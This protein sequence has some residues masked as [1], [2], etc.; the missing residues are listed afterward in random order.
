MVTW[1]LSLAMLILSVSFSSAPTHYANFASYKFGFEVTPASSF[2]GVC[3]LTSSTTKPHGQATAG[4]CGFGVRK[5]SQPTYSGPH[6]TFNNDR[7]DGDPQSE[8]AATFSGR[9]RS[10]LHFRQRSRHQLF[11]HRLHAR[12]PILQRLRTRHERQPI[13]HGDR[14]DQCAL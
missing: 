2:T 10:R 8:P 14:V 13:K 5:T 12:L 3:S 1:S 7:G 11:Q 9:G 6:S 4:P